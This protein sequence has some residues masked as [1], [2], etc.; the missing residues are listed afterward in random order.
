[1]PQVSKTCHLSAE[2]PRRERLA[3]R[4]FA[5]TAGDGAELASVHAAG[6]GDPRA[7]RKRSG[8]N[9]AGARVARERRGKGAASCWVGRPFRL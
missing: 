4:R 2:R 3:V 9:R 6:A 7:D 8:G 5:V 1:V